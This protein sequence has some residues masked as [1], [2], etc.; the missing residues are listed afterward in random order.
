MPG[1]TDTAFFDTIGTR[2]AIGGRMMA[3]VTVVRAAL[4]ALD[5]DRAYVVPG[6]SNQIGA[7]LTPRRPRR[8]VTA[9]SERVTRHVLDVSTPA[10]TSETDHHGSAGTPLPS[11]DAQPPLGGQPA[12]SPAGSPDT[13]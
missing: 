5:R 8:L 3:P 1:P 9:I 10:F 6:F 4:R 12:R 7:H 2:A 13:T 11:N